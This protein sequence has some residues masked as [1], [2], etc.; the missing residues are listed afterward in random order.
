[1]LSR[2]YRPFG[3]PRAAMA[4]VLHPQHPEP[5]AEAGSWLS[6]TALVVPSEPT[7]TSTGARS[8]PSM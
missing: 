1:M 6:Q 4:W 8:G 7:S 5:R 3:A 2:V